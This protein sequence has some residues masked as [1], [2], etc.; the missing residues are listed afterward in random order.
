M[1]KKN[2]FATILLLANCCVNSFPLSWSH[3]KTCG[4][5]Q[6]RDR[7]T[8]INSMEVVCRSILQRRSLSA[9]C[10]WISFFRIWHREPLAT[11]ASIQLGLATAKS[12]HTKYSCCS[13]PV[14]LMKTTRF[15]GA[16]GNLL[17]H[18]D[19][20]KQLWWGQWSRIIDITY[21]ILYKFK[22]IMFIIRIATQT[23][24]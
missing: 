24:P 7:R 2:S 22:Q 5:G 11:P 19:L 8:I 17:L 23:R 6:L 3:A 18:W 16:T 1:F 10:F 14:L 4:W 20:L 15:G 12:P 13:Y 21:Q 9:G